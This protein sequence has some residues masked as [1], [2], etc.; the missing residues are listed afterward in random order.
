M[1]DHEAFLTAGGHTPD[2]TTC[3]SCHRNSEQ[4]DWDEMWSKIAHVSD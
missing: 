3:R 1:A 4:F 2:E